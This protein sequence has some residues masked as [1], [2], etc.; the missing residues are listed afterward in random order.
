[1]PYVGRFAMQHAALGRAS[2]LCKELVDNDRDLRYDGSCRQP[3]RQD[4]EDEMQIE[5]KVPGQ[6]WSGYKKA[7]PA[8]YPATQK[9]IDFLTRLLDERLHE[10]D[11]GTIARAMSDKRECSRLIDQ[12]MSAGRKPQLQPTQERVTQ[13]GMYRTPSGEIFKVQRAVHGSGNL[14]A[15]LLVKLDEPI[16]KRGKLTYYELQYAKGAVRKL[17]PEWRMT[18]EEA[19]EW[20]ALYGSCCVCGATLTDEKSVEAGIGPVCAGRF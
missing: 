2:N 15:K 9:Q 14:Y 6:E 7:K 5:I 11:D 4:G 17:R 10:L 8:S 20:G 3:R 12:L 19:K 16:I 18:L 13:D 1:M